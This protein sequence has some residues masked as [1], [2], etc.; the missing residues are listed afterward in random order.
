MTLDQVTVDPAT[1]KANA[2][3]TYDIVTNSPVPPIQ[4]IT[5]YYR[6]VQTPATNWRGVVQTDLT[7]RNMDFKSVLTPGI[8][9]EAYIS[10][11]YTQTAKLDSAVTQFYTY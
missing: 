11:R 8:N 6:P 3:V 4:S 1:N 7:A 9:Y 5:L 2:W 10:V